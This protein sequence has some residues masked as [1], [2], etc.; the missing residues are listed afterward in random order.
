MSV[1]WHHWSLLYLNFGI[2]FKSLIHHCDFV[3]YMLVIQFSTSQG[4]GLLEL[5][6]AVPE[7]ENC[8]ASENFV[9]AI[10]LDLNEASYIVIF[11][12]YTLYS[13]SNWWP[14]FKNPIIVYLFSASP[15]PP[16]TKPHPQAIDTRHRI[17]YCYFS[18]ILLS[19]IPGKEVVLVGFQ[20]W[21]YLLLS[22]TGRHKNIKNREKLK[23]NFQGIPYFSQ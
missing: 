3:V 2:S 20:P 15:S 10:I 14:H 4:T 16:A 9:L 17:P 13:L 7:R 12:L 8:L 6:H 11:S 23:P 19:C 21:K 18:I 5:I 22:W 1:I